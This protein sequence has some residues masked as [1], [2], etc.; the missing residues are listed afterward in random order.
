MAEAVSSARTEIAAP[1]KSSSRKW[2]VVVVAVVGLVAV[3]LTI[4]YTRF[5][6][7]P[8]NFQVIEKDL[9]RGGKQTDRI[10][11]ELLNQ[12]K[13]KTVVSLTGEFKEQEQAA[14]DAGAKYVHYAWHG[15][16]IGPFEEYQAV[17]KLLKEAARPTF[18]HCYGGD[19]RASAATF[20]VSLE[21]GMT[22]DEA[23]KRLQQFGF[24]NTEDSALYQHLKDYAAWREKNA[25]TSSNPPATQH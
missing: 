8:K 6:F 18:Y 5:Y 22:P 14:T 2:L 23:F 16:G 24:S 7:I 25:A 4:K 17:G 15:S 1:P 9:Y 21:E 13:F 12:Y 11:V 20:A 3:A 10:F 19:K